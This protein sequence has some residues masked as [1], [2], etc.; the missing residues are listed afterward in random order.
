MTKAELQ[1]FLIERGSH[2]DAAKTFIAAI[3][4]GANLEAIAAEIA[5]T[6]QDAAFF[7]GIRQQA[8]DRAVKQRPQGATLEERLRRLGMR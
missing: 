8:R 2:P 4:E 6:Q 3:R 7:E 1:A 5:L